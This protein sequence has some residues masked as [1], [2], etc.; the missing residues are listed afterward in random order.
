VRKA[1][2]AQET[3]ARKNCWRARNGGG[4]EAVPQETVLAKIIA[5]PE[6]IDLPA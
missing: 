3:L 4:Q 2:A 6:S 5:P 1:A